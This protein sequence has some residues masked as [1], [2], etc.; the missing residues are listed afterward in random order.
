MNDTPKS[1]TY[2]IN[3]VTD[4]KGVTNASMSYAD[5]EGV[6]YKT[7]ASSNDFDKAVRTATRS[8]L[9]GIV[10]KYNKLEQSKPVEKGPDPDTL[11]KEHN[12]LIDK[13]DQLKRKYDGLKEDYDKLV[14]KRTNHV[15]ALD[16]FIDQLTSRWGL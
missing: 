9:S 14:D 3:C 6:R 10:D 7:S 5:S 11:L 13:Y 4:G 12:D 8:M 16:N 1:L 15:S 2:S